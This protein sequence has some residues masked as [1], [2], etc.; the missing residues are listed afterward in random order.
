MEEGSSR[1][2]GGGGAE[3]HSGFQQLREFRLSSCATIELIISQELSIA[4]CVAVFGPNS[5]Q[6]LASTIGPLVEVP[7]LLSLTW[8]A[9]YLGRRLHWGDAPLIA[10]PPPSEEEEAKDDRIDRGGTV[11]LV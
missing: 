2:H 4:V 3:L 9:L 7:V 8:V 1:V 6:A 11:D 5:D 10:P